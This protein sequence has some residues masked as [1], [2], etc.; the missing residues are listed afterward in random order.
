MKHITTSIIVLMLFMVGCS[1]ETEEKQEGNGKPVV[2]T[3]SLQLTTFRH[4]LNIQGTV[5]SDKTIMIT[6]KTSATVESINV[7]AGDQVERGD[8]LAELDGEVT[9]REIDEV[10]NQLELA[11]TVYERQKNLREEDIGSELEFLEAQ[12][13]MQSLRNQLATLRE[14]FENYTIEATIAGTVDRVSIKE[15]ENVDPSA[16]AF[17]IAN[18]EALKV[19]AEISEAYIDRVETTDSLTITL[20]SIDHEI[21]KTIDVVSRVIDPSNRTFAVEIY[22]SDPEEKIRPNMLAKLR[23]ND[24]TREDVLVVPID[25]IQDSNGEKVAYVAE[26]MDDGWVTRER[27]V[28]TG[29]SYNNEI[30]VEEGLEPDDHLITVGYNSVSDGDEIA[31]EEN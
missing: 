25:A 16:P 19:T 20:P 9:R 12:T 15:G 6:P 28:K 7:K 8:V 26:E 13:Q 24:T 18:S 1:N 3:E 30:V 31:I 4:F 11:E 21:T 5:E 10:E 27:K 17:Q 23:I 22:I 29:L 2:E 14:Q